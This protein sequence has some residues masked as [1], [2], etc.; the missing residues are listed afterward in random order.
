MFH[1][2]PGTEIIHS[3]FAGIDGYSNEQSGEGPDGW[4]VEDNPDA[5]RDKSLR[6]SYMQDLPR[7]D[8]TEFW[9]RFTT[10]ELEG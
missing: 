3:N 8:L 6:F 2:Q 7:A 1:F 4:F 5:M 9:T 10:Q